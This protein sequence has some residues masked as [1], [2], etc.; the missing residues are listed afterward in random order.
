MNPIDVANEIRNQYISYL[1]TSFGLSDSIE[2][3]GER[4]AELLSSPGQ[5]LAG[6]FLEATAPYSPGESTLESLIQSGLLHR[7]FEQLLSI[8]E[9]IAPQLPSSKNP[10][11]FGFKK[12]QSR[13][14]ANTSSSRRNERLPRDRVLY[15]H[16]EEA[17]GRLSGDIENSGR[18]RHTVV[19]SGTGSGKTECF[20]IPALD[21]IL[22]HPTRVSEDTA[23]GKGIRVLLVYPMNALVNDQV[24]RLKQLV[25]YRR[26]KGESFLPVTFARY[27][28]ETAKTRSE[29]KKHE[30]NAPDNQLLG[31][32]EI[33]S[34]PP[35]IL[36]TNFAMLEQAL[37]RPQESPF[38]EIVDEFSWRFLI[39]D[40]AHS[41]RGAQGIELA[42][43]MQR[44]RSA[45]RHGKSQAMVH[46][47]EPICIATSATLASES[48]TPQERRSKTAEFAGALFGSAFSDESV[49]FA[50]RL[51]PTLDSEI[52]DFPNEETKGLADHAWGNIQ[53]GILNDLDMPADDLFQNA[54]QRIVPS[55]VWNDARTKA[56]TDRRSFLYWLLRGHPR[57]HWLWNSVRDLPTQF[58]KLATE[59]S[60][61]AADDFTTHLENLVSAC[62]AAR[63]APGEQPLLPCRY[64]L[65]VSALEGFFVDLASDDELLAPLQDWDVAGIGVKKT[66]VRRIKPASQIAFELS[67]CMNCRYP[68]VSVD[69]APQTE[70][71]DQPPIWTRPVQFLAFRAD[72]SEGA[73]LAEVKVDLRDGKLEG[74]QSAG[75][76]IWRTLYRVTG[77]TDETDIQTCPN[78]GYDHRH[79]RVT[80]RFQT[81]QDAPVSLL[82]ESLYSQLPPL[83]SSAE[84]QLRTEFAHRFGV[85]ED[86]LVG[87]GR[88]LLVFSDSRQNAAFMASYLQDHSREYLVREIAY[89]ALSNATSPLTLSDWACECMQRIESRKLLSPYLQDRDLTDV[90]GSPFRESYLNSQSERKNQLL[91]L[92]LAELVGTQ[93]LV[94]ESLGLLTVDWSNTVEEFF[95]SNQEES[96]GLDFSW[97]G[98]PMSFANLKDLVQRVF[99][100]MRRKYL[101]TVPAGVE[102]PGF[103]NHQHYLIFEK[104]PGVEGILHGMWNAAAQD[105]IFTDLLRRWG[106]RRSGVSPSDDQIRQLLTY[107][108]DGLREANELGILF[109]SSLQSGLKSLVIRHDGIRIRE[110]DQLWRCNSCRGYASTFLDGVCA[111]PHCSGTL[112]YV[113]AANMPRIQP[114]S[115]MFTNRFVNGRRIE[116]RC[117]EHTAQI[118]SELGQQIQEAFQCGQVNVLSCSTTFEMGIDIGA[119]QAVVL[120]NVP[121]ST[122]NYLQ[123]AGR[124]GRRADSVAFVLTYCQRRPHDRVYFEKPETIIAGEVTPPRIDLQ[125]KKILQRHC[126]AE[127]LSEYWAWLNF[128]SV[129]GQ[130]NQFRTSGTVGAYF[131]DRLDKSNCTPAEYLRIWIDN[132][133][134]MKRCLQRIQESFK[135]VDAAHACNF[136]N[137]V[138]DMTAHETNPLAVAADDAVK[139]LRSF[140]DGELRHNENARKSEDAAKIAR[141]RNLSNEEQTSNSER[142]DELRMGRSFQKLLRQQRKEP[143]IGFLMSRGVLPSFAFPVNVSKLH[144]L[145]E[146]FNPDRSDADSS[147]LRFERDGKIA[148]GEYA[149]GSEVVAG[150]R[151]YKS[152]GLRKFPALEFDHT[153]WFR[154]CSNCNALEVWPEGTEKPEDVKPECSTCGQPIRSGNDAPKQWVAPRWGFVTDAK[155]KGKLPHGQRPN[156]LHATRAFFLSN[157]HVTAN[158]SSQEADAPHSI[159]DASSEVRVDG[160]YSTGRSLLVLNLGDFDT[161][162]NG[163]SRRRG[164]KLCGSCGRV[165]FDSKEKERRHRPPYHTKGQS[166]TGPIGIGTN[167]NGQPVALGHRY[168]T[169]VVL[170]D[171]FGT[172]RSG[173]DTGF[174]L[175][176]AYALTNGACQ[177]LN[178]ERSDLEVTTVPIDN[179]SRQSIVIYDAVPGGAGHCRQIL[180]AMPIVARRALAMLSSCDCDPDS[181]G[182]YGCLCVYQNQFAHESLSRGGA[183]GYLT[184]LI[185]T[186]ESGNPDPWREACASPGR[187]LASALLASSGRI[188]IVLSKLCTGLIRGLNRDWFDVLKELASRPCG[189]GSLK[190]IIGKVPV[191]GQDADSTIA[192]HRIAELQEIGVE[193]ETAREFHRQ[194]SNAK[195]YDVAGNISS[196]WRWPWMELGPGLDKVQ[197]NRL[198]RQVDAAES[199]EAF[200]TST[201]IRNQCLR[202]FH[203]FTLEPGKQHN[204]FAPKYLGELLRHEVLGAVIVDPHIT[205]SRT[206]LAVLDRFISSL[207]VSK[208]A[209]IKVRAGRVRRDE[210][211]GNFTSWQEQDQACLDLKGKHIGLDLT[212]EFPSVGYFVDHDRLVFLHVNDGT[213]ERFYKLILGQGLFGFDASC[214][215][216]SHGV[217][218]EIAEP[219][220]M[221]ICS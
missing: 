29:G 12:S 155:E 131:E 179:A 75:K 195:V 121:P 111:L 98:P 14:V 25:G 160:S 189:A 159:P 197:Q 84:Q 89:E 130:V 68:F 59:W 177:E 19:A 117:E 148:L 2:K 156:R 52:W 99:L 216:R 69:L 44:L 72:Q 124:A 9:P 116:L 10:T 36:I 182:C 46:A 205:H 62:N 217:W 209:K 47:T 162:R 82:V 149:P 8:A 107:V 103:S 11:G 165:H 90:G 213:R 176:L 122:A 57:F 203:E 18:D 86:P 91:Q 144:V 104:A 45:I 206:Q 42:R 27:T 204:L 114:K 56:G 77:S 34:N 110:P 184:R 112:E 22:R 49:I 102:R 180:E 188:E 48:M 39:L 132:P 7:S 154:W 41:Y 54:W 133:A 210:L 152:V 63:R 129:G 218:F 66:A 151:V 81:G 79:H 137:T 87:E 169:D 3:L 157:R 92:L 31:R 186:I 4:F 60:H 61:Q 24:R 140:R 28:S 208:Q 142:N 33:V 192:Y 168:E 125:N 20:L 194:Y 145:R 198:G 214:R 183:M 196:V 163:I 143:L 83:T 74:Q 147:R 170:L 88:K 190:L 93:S 85:G 64:H 50:N 105:T 6:P 202:E 171:F 123:R 70:G 5:V 80:G 135:D 128:Q 58:E 17:I 153:N 175:S 220:W 97:P 173:L 53:S 219:E 158:D 95:A 212:I 96:L 119:L 174:W 73:P 191:F 211:R 120:R 201:A 108:F 40:E 207:R 127:I 187:E 136:I 15:R 141:S 166:C 100:L 26:D 139:L 21:W 51:D 115:H 150:K 23:S 138:A 55:T 38:F 37:L 146:E 199:V 67:R 78:C 32:D 126:N 200:P 43:L 71:L 94:L 76:P 30:P 215:R 35:D 65:F 221:K 106:K 185:D 16:Q 13:N 118:S 113:P 172:G 181:T 164:F 1:S 167:Q 178:I 134:N 109:E 161:D 101:V 193:V